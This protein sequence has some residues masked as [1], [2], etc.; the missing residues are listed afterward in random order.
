MEVLEAGVQ[1]GL[2]SGEWM[3]FVG[4]EGGYQMISGYGGSLESLEWDRGASRAWRVGRQ[5][6]HL[7]VEGRGAAGRCVI[8][9][10]APDQQARKIL[11]QAAL[12]RV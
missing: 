5:R 8:E 2:A 4:P 12:Y 6:G 3:V 11:S 1:A 9:R 10:A 7:V